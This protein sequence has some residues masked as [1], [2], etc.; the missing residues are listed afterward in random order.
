MTNDHVICSKNL[1]ATYVGL[2]IGGYN[3]ADV[4][5]AHQI[6]HRINSMVYNE[7]IQRYFSI[8]RTASC[9]VNPYWPR[10]YLLTL[11][12]F[13]IDD[14]FSV[15]Q[16]FSQVIKHIEGLDNINPEEKNSELI[17]WLKELPLYLRLISQSPMF[18]EIWKLYTENEVK[19]TLHICN[20]IQGVIHN[21]KS[22]LGID[23]LDLP[24]LVVI[25]NCLQAPQAT[26][27]IKLKR[28]IYVIK[29]NPDKE[30]II[31]EYLHEIFKP[32]LDRNSDLIIK[33]SF[34]LKPVLSEMKRLQYAWGEDADSW[35]NVFEENF[36]RAAALWITH[37]D[38][39]SI[40]YAISQRYETEGFAYVPS[41][42]NSFFDNWTGL[43]DFNSF[44]EKCLNSCMK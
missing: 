35:V 37:K 11:A 44:L 25:P 42:F 12:S 28:K 21:I 39:Y 31:H 18:D 32:Y 43:N 3:L 19:R 24:D 22:S 6:H 16:D 14:G 30:S 27:Y 13:Y 1:F 36:M 2:I 20:E 4:V 7:D 34:L 9:E 40:G 5:Q 23:G 10:A 26:D 17:N 8:A 38:V 41:V 15:Y 33:Y 29:A